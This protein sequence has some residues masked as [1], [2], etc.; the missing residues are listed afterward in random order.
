M[1]YSAKRL[2]AECCS[3]APSTPIS[4]SSTASWHP[5]T[6]SL[7]GAARFS[8]ESSAH[9]VPDRCNP[10]SRIPT[11]S[12]QCSQRMAGFKHGRPHCRANRAFCFNGHGRYRFPRSLSEPQERLDRLRSSRGNHHATGL[13]MGSWSRA[14]NMRLK[15]AAPVRCCRIAFVNVKVWRRSLGAIRQAPTTI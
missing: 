1:A 2:R 7:S 6:S 5:G 10:E 8:G 11:C 14:P 4:R 3:A 15:L 12:A 13:L 9:N